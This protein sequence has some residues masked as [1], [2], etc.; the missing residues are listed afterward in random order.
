MIFTIYRRVMAVLVQKPFRLWGIS[1]LC[2]LLTGVAWTFFGLI[3]GIPFAIALLLTASM[4]MVYLRGYRKEEVKCVQLFDA[5]KDGKTLKRVLGG[6]AW[7]ELWIFLWALIPIVGIVFAIIRA[8]EYRLTPYI[9]MTEPDVSATEAIKISKERT[10]GWKS[11]MFGADLLVLLLVLAA[12]LVLSLLALIPFI[13]VLF[14]I[15]GSLFAL[16]VLVFLPLFLGLVRA[17]FYEEITNP[18]V[19]EPKFLARYCPN[20]GTAVTPETIYCP[21]C[22]NQI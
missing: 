13:G 1:L 8:Y 6:M 18:T 7:M 3:P 10:Y 15:I 19:E 4:A 20:C 21:N 5:F 17:A 11:K 2:A 16:A 14:R 22:G 12:M 9:L